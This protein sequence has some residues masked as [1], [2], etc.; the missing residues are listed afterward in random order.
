MITG[1][2]QSDLRNTPCIVIAILFT[3]L[4]QPCSDRPNHHLSYSSINLRKMSLTRSRSMIKVMSALKCVDRV[5]Q[6]SDL[7][8]SL[9]SF[10]PNSLVLFCAVIT[11]LG[12][13]Q[14]DRSRSVAK[15]K[16][17]GSVSLCPLL[18]CRPA[19][20]IRSCST[21]ASRKLASQDSMRSPRYHIIA[22][23]QQVKPRLK[24]GW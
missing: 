14:G 12:R 5:E 21:W 23:P 2:P 9:R 6:T 16:A 11:P 19:R 15:L 8:P 7:C 4:N 1:G 13:A 20:A 24:E 10:S 22:R 3:I 17:A 18:E